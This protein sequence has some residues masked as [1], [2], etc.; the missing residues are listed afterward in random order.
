MTKTENICIIGGGSWATGLASLLAHHT[1]RLHWYI[2]NPET[3]RYFHAH[4]HNP[5][6]LSAIH[7]D[8][9][10]IL[11]YNDINEA[12][13]NADI[14]VF[15]IPA[16]YLENTLKSLKL[17]LKTKSIISGIKGILP[18]QNQTVS[19]FFHTQY[20]VPNEQ[21]GIVSGPCHAEEIAR[22]RLSYLT[23]A[24]ESP[25]WA[26]IIA[27][28]F[29][30]WFIK[31]KL[32][33]DVSGIEYASVLKNIVALCAGVCHGL[34]Y[35]DN[36]QSVLIANATQQIE[37]V[38]EQIS[39]GQRNIHD[40]VYL[41]DLLVTSYSQFSRNRKL[42]VMIGKGYSV[43]SAL[44]EMNMVAEG[45]YSTACLQNMGIHMPIQETM[46]NI[47]YTHADPAEEIAL[48]AEGLI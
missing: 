15:A 21:I 44:L 8:T 17:P 14:L 26:H 18:Q 29:S 42:G 37:D 43:D 3:I 16:A 5:H 32:S 34:D 20:E 27:S 24:S 41:G 1:D 19:N 38:L 25:K 22:E 6:Y 28:W 33:T 2:R 36:F 31:T 7:F 35:G 48:L 13:K 12:V 23:F 4:G 11:F 47:L 46:Y 45:Y 40:S 10:R 39:P 30:Q 9:E